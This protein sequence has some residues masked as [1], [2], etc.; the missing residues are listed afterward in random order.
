MSKIMECWECGRD[1]E[2]KPRMRADHSVEYLCRECAEMQ[3]ALDK[4]NE[5]Q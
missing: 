2:C 4:R 5:S 1:R 3:A